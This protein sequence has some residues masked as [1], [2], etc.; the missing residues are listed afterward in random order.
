MRWK[1]V[2]WLTIKATDLSDWLLRKRNWNHTAA[3]YRRMPEN[4][5]GKKLI[6]YMDENNIPFKPNLVRHDLKHILLGYKMNMP[7]ELRI[8]AFLIGNRS[9][10]PMAIIYLLTCTLL[11]PE[12]I[13]T[14]RT[15]YKRGQKAV[16][17]K[18]LNLENFVTDD[19]EKC[20]KRW[21]IQ[22]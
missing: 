11:V 20:Q 5:I 17:L 22:I 9:Y 2:T 13:P 14:L 7:D 15:D 21:K 3:D 12:I 18:Q 19:L 10:N 16:C 8:H 4:S 6:V 1:L